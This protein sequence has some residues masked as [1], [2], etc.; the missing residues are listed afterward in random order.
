V[1]A[2]LA[3]AK[4][5]QYVQGLSKQVVLDD[6][7]YRVEI[8]TFDSSVEQ[9]L[10]RYEII[11]GPGDEI[12]PSIE[13]ALQDNTEIKI[14][15]AME[16][17]V[18][19]DGNKEVLH[20][21]RGTVR[22]VLEKANVSLGEHDI[23]SYPLN[24]QVRPF[25]SIEVTRTMP[26]TVVADG[27]EEVLHVVGGT[28]QDILAEANVSLREKDII[29]YPLSQQVKPNDNIKVTRIDEEIETETEVI[30]YKVVTR[31]NNSMDDGITKLVQEGQQG[32][33]ERRTLVTYHD[34][35]EINRE[36][37]SEKVTVK[38]QNRIIEKGTIKR[39]TTGRGDTVRYTKT[40]KMTATAYTAF[41]SGMNGKGITANGSKVKS[42][43]TIAA[44]PN[45]PFGTKVYIPELVNYW[46]KRGVSIS[47]IF[48]VEDRGGAIKGNKID[49]YMEDKSTT[50]NWGRRSV[51]IY[52]LR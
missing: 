20:V 5:T 51:T 28:V 35:M 49:I 44:P 52:I 15:R 24:Q 19:A 34:G 36:L 2:G 33:L 17:S 32:E 1:I 38:P 50:L 46:A 4:L 21:T 25:D 29:N 13:E 40:R 22:E 43:H 39:V 48:T 9:L 12:V 26:V 10:D 14:T 11:L 27:Q 31:N 8:K 23:I 18:A 45:I 6:D 3:A 41:D 30:P 42:F 16:I 47:G 7:G 37:V